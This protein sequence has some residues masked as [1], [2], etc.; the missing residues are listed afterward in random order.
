MK[1]SSNKSAKAA[2]GKANSSKKSATNTSRKAASQSKSN[3]KKGSMPEHDVV[4]TQDTVDLEMFTKGT[5][6]RPGESRP[7]TLMC[8]GRYDYKFE[9]E[10]LR[11][12]GT[13]DWEHRVLVSKF[14]KVNI[15]VNAYG[16][17]LTGY[18][19]KD[20]FDDTLELAET[21]AD[22]AHGACSKLRKRD[23]KAIMD[24]LETLKPEEV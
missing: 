15:K 12:A 18:W 7:G 16:V 21:M 10:C 23:V 17:F 1:K 3:G 22:D 14:G 19:R 24:E 4:K 8:R 5:E 2:A 13:R 6:F 20:E 11:N 9:E